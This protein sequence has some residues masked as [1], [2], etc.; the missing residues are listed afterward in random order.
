MFNWIKLL[1]SVCR[2]KKVTNYIK[3]LLWI[4]YEQRMKWIYFVNRITMCN[5]EAS[6]HVPPH[7]PPPSILPLNRPVSKYHN[8]LCCPPPQILYKHC[9]QFLLGI[10]VAS[11]EIENNSYAK[12][13]IMVLKKP[14]WNRLFP[15]FP[16]PLYQN[17]VKCLAYDRTNKNVLSSVECRSELMRLGDKFCC[18]RRWCCYATF[19][20]LLQN[21]CCNH[22][23][24]A[25]M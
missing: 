10:A 22:N 20:F 21:E 1:L 18:Q 6:S 3:L 5:F 13:S 2:R 23:V 17:E 25:Q 12:T 24:N 19:S 4:S 7:P 15:S 16:V 8:T 14:L 11:R 9:F